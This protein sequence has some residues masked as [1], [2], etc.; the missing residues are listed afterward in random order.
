[1]PAVPVGW[2]IPTVLAP[3]FRHTVNYCY[4]TRSGMRMQGIAGTMN[5]RSEEHF[6]DTY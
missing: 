5:V 2:N 3:E 4:K 6:W 1:M